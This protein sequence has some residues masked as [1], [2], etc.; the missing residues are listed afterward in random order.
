MIVTTRS[1]REGN[2]HS[3]AMLKSVYLRNAPVLFCNPLYQQAHVT[4]YLFL[5]SE[6]LPLI[7]FAL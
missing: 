3:L 1:D 6:I 2:P 7:L 4:S 5:Y